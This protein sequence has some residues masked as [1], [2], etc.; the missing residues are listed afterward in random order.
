M[1]K[2]L[3][4]HVTM[5]DGSTVC[6]YSTSGDRYIS[7]SGD[8]YLPFVRA[9]QSMSYDHMHDTGGLCSLSFGEV[10]FDN[11]V[12]DQWRSLNSTWFPPPRE[13]A[14]SL[15]IGHDD[16]SIDQFS[17]A[18]PLLLSGATAE[19]TTYR[20]IGV[21]DEGLS[22]DVALGGA[23]CI[24]STQ[25]D[26]FTEVIRCIVQGGGCEIDPAD[27]LGSTL[28]Y[29]E[30]RPPYFEGDNCMYLSPD[31]KSVAARVIVPSGRPL[32]DVASS[33]A[34]FWCHLLVDQLSQYKLVDALTKR[35][36]THTIDGSDLVDI[37]YSAQ[38]PVAAVYIRDFDNGILGDADYELGSFGVTINIGRHCQY[39]SGG[40][41][42]RDYILYKE[43]RDRMI[44]WAGKDRAIVTVP[45]CSHLPGQWVSFVDEQTYGGSKKVQFDGIVRTVAYDTYRQL[46]T[47]H[48]YGQRTAV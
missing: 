47:L 29:S 33:T 28:D 19:V 18:L 5:P 39:F 2:T 4:A 22:S 11:S 46:E 36:Q 7:S 10:S 43:A 31:Q 24:M 25:A 15:Y 34:A 16:G 48:V 13:L 44:A 32:Y 1:R 14:V 8:M 3:L 42:G 17:P 37:E 12:I 20:V 35:S 38:D 45:I 30:A 41:T 9:V 21:S 23:D 26:S 27:S 6:R 40:G